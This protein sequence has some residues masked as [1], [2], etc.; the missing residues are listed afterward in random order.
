MSSKTKLSMIL[1]MV[2]LSLATFSNMSDM[3]II[4]VADKIYAQFADVNV[5]VINFILSG[6]AILSAIVAAVS[7]KIIEKIGSKKFMIIGFT[8]YTVG[9]VFGIVFCNAYFM[10]AM[11][12]LVGIGFGCTTVAAMVI[13][14]ETFID[15]DQRS[16][17]IGVYNGMMAAMGALL[18]FISGIVA[19]FG[20]EQV[21][22]IYLASIPIL[23]LLII[24]IPNSNKQSQNREDVNVKSLDKQDISLKKVYSTAGGFFIYGLIYTVV[25]YQVSII[26]VEKGIT[27]V[28]MI[29]TL[30]ALG[31]VGSFIACTLFGLYYKLLKRYTI[32]LGFAMQGILFTMLY[33][34]GNSIII[35]CIIC[36]LLGSSFGLGM[37]YYFSY[38]TTIV[39]SEKVPVSISIANIANSLSFFCST[40]LVT[41]LQKILKVSTVTQIIPALIIVLI[42]STILSF[43]CANKDNKNKLKSINQL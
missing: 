33:F 12:F 24:F 20:W 11:R 14:S 2:T 41:I 13:L 15:E 23:I 35:A 5:S 31:T 25:Y 40:Y 29:G 36:T 17:M 8:I 26:M 28:S 19:N 34:M 42:M 6:P 18:G 10:A 38:I 39:P 32:T 3:V 16:T 9:A 22:K 21:F 4:T 1:I 30:S 43:I 7:A 27:S 37:S